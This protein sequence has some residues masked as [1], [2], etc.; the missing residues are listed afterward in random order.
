MPNATGPK[1][2]GSYAFG[3]FHRNAEELERLKLQARI[4]LSLEQDIWTH[5]GLAS[6]MDVLD[7]GCG[8]G[9]ISCELARRIGPDGRVTGLDVSA[10]LIAVAGQIRT[11]EQA[12]N[13]TFA[14]GSAY[15]LPF[16]DN[17]FDFIYARLL[18]QHLRDPQRALAQVRRVLKPGGIFCLLDVD[19]NWTSFA[20]ASAAFIRFIRMAGAAQRRR[21]GN[22]MIGSQAYGLLAAA[23]FVDVATRIYPLTSETIG[24]RAFLGVA[25][26][27]RLELLGRLQKLLTLRF[28]RRIQ[29]AAGDPHAWGAVGIFVATGRRGEAGR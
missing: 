27:F 14:T 1:D 22:R 2:A 11:S 24:I 5:A 6:G 8:P 25:V 28:L 4:A 21:G 16:S 7:L 12:V 9:V 20:P 19:D 15:N 13:V 29:A 10:E 17:Q 23:G 18:F 3:Q 26:M